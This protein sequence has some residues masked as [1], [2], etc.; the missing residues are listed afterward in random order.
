[1]LSLTGCAK[2]KFADFTAREREAG[3]VE[4][5]LA[6]A[7]Q[8]SAPL[9]DQP[10]DCPKPETANV[11]SGERLDIALVKTDAALDRANA[12]AKACFDWYASI[13]SSHNAQ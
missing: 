11:K 5:A 3:L 4:Q 9:P 1:M 7:S 13:R 12:K 10:A 2:G 6:V 8:P